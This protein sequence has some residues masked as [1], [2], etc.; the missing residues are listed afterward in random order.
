[1][2]GFGGR[3]VIGGIASERDSSAETG[4]G[5]HRIAWEVGESCR[6]MGGVLEGERVEVGK[7]SRVGWSQGEW[8]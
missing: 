6:R 1:L 3:G 7:G 4:A 8:E 5:R 2:R